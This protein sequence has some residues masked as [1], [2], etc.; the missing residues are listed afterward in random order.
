MS[1]RGLS[2]LDY[3]HINAEG[4]FSSEQKEELSIE[5]IE[6]A[7]KWIKAFMVA[8]TIVIPEFTN[9]LGL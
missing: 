4:T 7:Q 3:L 1:R 9:L 6:Q 8:C 2:N 5:Q